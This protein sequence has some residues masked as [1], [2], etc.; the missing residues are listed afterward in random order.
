[1]INLPPLATLAG[2]DTGTDLSTGVE[3]LSGADS[4]PQNFLTLLGNRLLSLAQTTNSPGQT[5]DVTPGSAEKAAPEPTLGT[6]LAALSKPE[7]LSALL[8]PEKAKDTTKS[9]DD[10]EKPRTAALSDSDKQAL[11]ALFAMLPQAPLQPV[12]HSTVIKTG[13]TQGDANK[14]RNGGNALLTSAL[15]Q[16]GGGEGQ[17]SPTPGLASEGKTRIDSASPIMPAAIAQ[18]TASNSA[19]NGT[20]DFHSALN[21]LRHDDP[22]TAE[23]PTPPTVSPTLS[24][25]APLIAPSASA[26]A[27]TQPVAQLN[28]HLGSPEWQQA[29]SQQVLMFSRNG[30]QNAELRLHPQDL[31]SIQISLKLDNDQAQLSMV[32]GHSQVRAALEAALPHLRTALAENGINLGQSSVSSDA[33]PQHQGFNGQQEPHRGHQGGTFSLT[34]E[35]D[36]EITPIAVPTT[37]QARAADDG[38]VDIFA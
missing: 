8:T 13:D 31:G 24:A 6:L 2:T 23:P 1:M 29:L 14:P 19:L 16:L 9:A 35:S 7:T 37:L 38:A 25:S 26:T 33:F 22:K 20:E 11:Q 12:A 28:A 3:S 5:A 17:S 34:P 32:S 15:A 30:Q 27:M 21:A 10:K 4:T 18:N 36:N